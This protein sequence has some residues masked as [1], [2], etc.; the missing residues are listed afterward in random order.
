MRSPRFWT[1]AGPMVLT[2]LAALAPTS[3]ASHTCV[4]DRALCAQPISSMEGDP[5]TDRYWSTCRGFSYWSE[6]PAYGALPPDARR[7]QALYVCYIQAQNS[8]HPD[9]T[10]ILVTGQVPTQRPMDVLKTGCD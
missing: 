4:G 2:V 1:L 6:H 8:D 9:Q 3:A 5:T 10:C 7:F